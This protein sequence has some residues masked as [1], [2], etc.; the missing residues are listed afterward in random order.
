MLELLTGEAPEPPDPN[1]PLPHAIRSLLDHRSAQLETPRRLNSTIPHALAAIVSRCLA[2]NPTERYPDALVLAEDLQ[3]FLER[4]PLQF[5]SNPSRL[6]RAGNWA[7]RN[8]WPFAAATLAFAILGAANAERIK[9]SLVPLEQ[10]DV[11]LDAV[12]QIDAHDS[13]HGYKLLEPLEKSYPES[14]LI[15][16]YLAV[17]QNDSGYANKAAERIMSLFRDPGSEASAKANLKAWASGHA[18]VAG[19]LESLGTSLLNRKNHVL[20]SRVFKVALHLDPRLDKARSGIA[21][22]F[23]YLKE[24][25]PAH[26]LLSE[27]IREAPMTRP[28]DAIYLRDLYQQRAGV[29]ARWG[30]HLQSISPHDRPLAPRAILEEALAD[31]KQSDRLRNPATVAYDGE[32]LFKSHAIR[33][34]ALTTLGEVDSREGLPD[35]SRRRYLEARHILEKVIKSQSTDQANEL[36]RLSQKLE[37]S[38]ARSAALKRDVLPLVSTTTIPGRN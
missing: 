12:K 18:A 3:R 32:S 16:F 30:A 7:L 35:S 11:F 19:Q 38:E 14:T 37:S 31:L 36:M 15:P 33:V 1:V 24:Y 6:E 10:R 2:G 23:E 17:A 26:D 21:T 13:E 25:R 22:A 29:A 34:L 20:A 5:A 4:K 9:A 27:L 28:K 8:R